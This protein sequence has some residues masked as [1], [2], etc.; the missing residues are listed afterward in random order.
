[1][2]LA[3]P[4]RPSTVSVPRLR[5]SPAAVRE[6]AVLVLIIIVGAG[7]RFYQLDRLPPGLYTD[8]A[9]YALDAVDVL[10][11]ARPI[12]FPANNGREPLFI[13]TLAP[14]LAWLG[15]TPLAVRLPA[16]VFGTLNIAAVYVLGRSLFNRRVG[17]LAAAVAA[18]TLWAVALSRIGLRAT[19]WPALGAASLAL[20]AAAW[21][22][23]RPALLA[24]SGALW[25]LCFYTYLAARLL[26]V[27]LLAAGVF[28]YSAERWRG[29]RPVWPGR[30]LALFL[31]PLA[32]VAA[33][34]A[35]YA[36]REPQIYLGRVGQVSV[37]G[38]D[39]A[40]AA[41]ALL[42]N[43]GAVLAMFTGRG[44]LNARHNVPGR[45]VFDLLLGAAFWLGVALS[46]YRA[47]R[48]GDSA[49]ALTLLWTGT[50]LAPTVFSQDAPHFLRAIGA[51]PTVCVF[52]A[53][54]L[55]RVWNWAAGR[56]R[57]WRW[58]GQVLVVG[59]LIFNGARTALDYFGAYAQDP[60][61]AY[62]FQAA[63]VTL[64]RDARAYLAGAPGRR[65]LVDRRLWDSF[66]A[67]R[68]LLQPETAVQVFSMTDPLP[69]LRPETQVVVWPYGDQ[70]PASIGRALTGAVLIA[71]AAGPLFRNDQETTP[72]P[73]Y[74]AYTV[75]PRP[76]A[77]PAQ[78]AFAGGIILQAADV[79]WDGGRLRVALT[80]SAAQPVSQDL[81]VF[82]HWR[83]DGV[84]VAQADGPLGGELYPA[85]QWRPDDWVRQTVSLD[86]PAEAG[87]Q[88]FV[89]LYQYPSGERLRV[90]ANGA[91]AVVLEAP[92][93][94]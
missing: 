2:R 35:V 36:L 70:P 19:T 23:R 71:P 18:G 88:V 5:L 20:T 52:P 3:P 45:P 59:L 68:F 40:A 6:A 48:R 11:G 8:E 66:A 4:C 33:P 73:L 82:V 7:L 67:V 34:L 1:M 74:A 26:P 84:P 31:V 83:V 24:A 81:H 47:G 49:A 78:A 27:P 37:F 10:A 21:R 39:G 92:A 32:A 28:W 61:T 16:A 50:M 30:E 38:G 42:N 77:G 86:P 85:A 15:H 80:W 22:T 55:E 93:R 46:A 87:G 89:G 62:F 64:A 94:P 58:A 29:R 54:S 79:Q 57:G 65:V 90:T 41:A 13:Y 56:V 53:L 72:Y 12:Y 91:E 25:G 76:A 51:L 14:S 63:A 44:D 9:Y 75:A 17:L 69:A 60:N 43:L